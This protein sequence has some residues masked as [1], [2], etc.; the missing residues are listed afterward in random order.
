MCPIEHRTQTTVRSLSFA[1]GF[2][3]L[4]DFLLWSQAGGLSF[5][6]LIFSLGIGILAHGC[7]R[8]PL[9]WGILFLGIL[10]ST[11]AAGIDWGFCSTTLLLIG[12]LTL[13]GE[14]TFAQVMPRWHRGVEA[15]WAILKFPGRVFWLI[16]ETIEMIGNIRYFGT[17]LKWMILG[18][19]IL[20]ITAL[21]S[22][23]LGTG[24]AVLGQ[25]FISCTQELWKWIIR[26]E[27]EFSR[28]LLWGFLLLLGLAIFRPSIPSKIRFWTQ[29]LPSISWE[30]WKLWSAQGAI[31]LLF[32]LNGLFFVSNTIDAIYLWGNHSL[33]P[34]V[35]YSVYVHE[36]VW[37]L[38][39]AAILSG[40]L[41][42]FLWMQGDGI[43]KNRL[44]QTL[45]IVWVIQNMVL[46][47]GVLRRLVLYVQTYHLSTQR[48]YVAL[49]LIL[50]SVG[51]L[52]IALM[53]LRKKSVAW[54]IGAN[55]LST[56]GL[57]FVVQFLPVSY[58]V[59]QYNV[60]QWFQEREQGKKLDLKYLSELGSWS[61]PALSKVASEPGDEYLEIKQEAQQILESSQA[62]SPKDWRK[63]QAAD[64]F[65][66]K[67]ITHN[68]NYENHP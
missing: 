66:K 33:P 22:F 26:F 49:F 55:F 57:L 36:G 38:S 50:V 44:T 32:L 59:A 43:R 8:T 47:F 54:L 42:S 19:P 15:G 67:T 24:N 25:W 16:R 13:N 68:P 46:L 65:V 10:P 29:P 51:F 17:L 31:V 1:L 14:V 35:T 2:I 58:W 5:A 60:A 6:L 28:F 56:L 27:F 34:H 7:N 63:W 45:G 40:I 61:L 11:V 12:L 21:F 9:A 39:T 64:W 4:T 41:L 62:Q 23:F 18:I 30:P 52:L 48:T 53:I 20:G 3:A 37:S